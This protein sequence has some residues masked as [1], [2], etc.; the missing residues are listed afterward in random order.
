MFI[1]AA[2]RDDVPALKKLLAAGVSPN[3]GNVIGQTALHIACMW[4]NY[5][6]VGVILDAGA[7]T[8]ATNQFGT[9]PLLALA[10]MEKGTLRGRIESAKKMVEAGANLKVEDGD[11]KLAWEIVS[12]QAGSEELAKVLTPK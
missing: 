11:G 4:G 8:D 12:D 5:K 2:Q 1:Q 6:S 10:R 9:T 7:N 3:H